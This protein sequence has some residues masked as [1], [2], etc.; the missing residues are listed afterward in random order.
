MG[1]VYKANSILET[2]I[3]INATTTKHTAKINQAQINQAQSAITQ[4]S[5]T[6]QN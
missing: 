1:Y 6:V 3:L 2:T 5:G 4:E